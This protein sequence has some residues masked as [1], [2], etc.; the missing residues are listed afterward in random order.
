M[1]THRKRW[2]IAGGAFGAIVSALAVSVGAGLAVRSAAPRNTSPP[3]VSGTPQEGKTLSGDRGTWSGNP[4]DFNL[5]WTRCDKTGGSCANI[6]G[7]NRTTYTL[8]SA[9]VENTLRFKVEARNADGSTFA[10]S[11]PTAVIAKA[12]PATPPRGDGCPPGGNPD[13]VGGISPPARLL[14]DQFQAEPAVVTSG[15][16]TLIVRFHVTST[17][18]GPV[19]GALVYATATPYN[20]F[21]IPSEQPSGSDGWAVLSMPRLSGFPVS[22]RQQLIAMF[23]RARKPGE[24][25]LSGISTRRLVSVR[26]DLSR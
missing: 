14:V 21:S 10:S 4:T 1:R 23:V 6:S 19:Q 16:G 3:T 22:P 20:Q 7:A 2:L 26:V 9:D 15:T 24:N 13:S 18:G 17:C 12:T 25:L 5:F 11:V 8:T